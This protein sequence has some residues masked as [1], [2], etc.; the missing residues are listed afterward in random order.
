MYVH[1]LKIS[2]RNYKLSFIVLYIT[3]IQQFFSVGVNIH[4]S[5]HSTYVTSV[6]LCLQHLS[7]LFCPSLIVLSKFASN[8]QSFTITM[9]C[10]LSPIDV[11]REHT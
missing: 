2:T 3:I 6:E 7:N 11:R 5:L 8:I 1:Y 10:R 9:V 4:T